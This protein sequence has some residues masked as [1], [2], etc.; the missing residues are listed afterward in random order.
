MDKGLDISEISM[1]QLLFDILS[2]IDNI[3]MAYYLDEKDG[4]EVLIPVWR[5]AAEK[6]IYYFNVRNGNI[7]Y[8]SRVE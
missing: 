6:R 1:D 8:R 3:Q 7:I 4:K 5:I 2:S